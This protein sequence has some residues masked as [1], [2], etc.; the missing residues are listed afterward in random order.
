MNFCSNCDI[1]AA[2]YE[3]KQCIDGSRLFCEQCMTIHVK[4]KPFKEHTFQRL[5]K[6]VI[7]CNNCDS[8][9]AKYVCRECDE[10]CRYLCVG[11]SV[12]H[13]KIKAFRGHMVTALASDGNSS[14]AINHLLKI[15]N[16]LDELSTTLA[17]IIELIYRN[18]SSLS[19]TDPL[20]IQTLVGLIAVSV[21]YYTIIRFVFAKYSS[22]VNIAMAIGLYQWLQS[23]KFKVSESNK[24]LIS[25]KADA[26]S[27][28][29]S[30]SLNLHS[31]SGSSNIPGIGKLNKGWNIGVDQFN[32]E[33]FK[34]EF[35]YSTEDKKASL[36][37]RGR[38]YR[39]RGTVSTTGSD[40]TTPV[41]QKPNSQSIQSAQSADNS[42]ISSSSVSFSSTIT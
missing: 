21:G 15:P 42:P 1:C 17:Q 4:V 36:R 37:P 33:E 26:S 19:W 28:A 9:Q 18:L 32:K 2:V 11:C 40:T 20:F 14:S 3:C 12:I 25:G 35:W 8:S 13:P 16:S 5:Q 30:L 41:E 10:S 31:R 29:T 38:P 24:Q 27:R 39:S 23:A 7:L 34:D 6:R 22:V